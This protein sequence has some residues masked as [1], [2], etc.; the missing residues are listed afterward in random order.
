MS[1]QT[2]TFAPEAITQRF[3]RAI[4]FYMA[5]HDLTQKELAAYWDMQE[6]HLS[7]MMNGKKEISRAYLLKALKNGISINY[8][9]GGVGEMYVKS[10]SKLNGPVSK[11][12]L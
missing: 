5:E 4:R 11:H 12:G 8:V 3:A 7:T 1:K 2:D 6:T 10:K 9:L